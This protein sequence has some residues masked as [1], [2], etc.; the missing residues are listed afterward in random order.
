MTKAEKYV[1]IKCGHYA[2][3]LIEFDHDDLIDAYNAG[4]RESI[5]WIDVNHELPGP[6][7]EV[8]SHSQ[9]K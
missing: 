7:K 9:R 8:L 5:N 3:S 6:E 1:Q 4:A 2:V